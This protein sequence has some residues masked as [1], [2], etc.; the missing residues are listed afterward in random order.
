MQHAA[1][2]AF[3]P[4]R[5]PW[6]KLRMP[7]SLRENGPGGCRSELHFQ[8]KCSIRSERRR[9]LRSAVAVRGL[10]LGGASVLLLLLLTASLGRAATAGR[11][12]NGHATVT[13]RP[14]G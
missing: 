3:L 1:I 5:W 8:E 11:A 6:S 14:P 9:R 12:V 2:G 7:F 13:Q 4:V 10:W